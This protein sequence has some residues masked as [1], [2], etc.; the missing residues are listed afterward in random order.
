MKKYG[1]NGL[2]KILLL[3]R[4]VKHVDSGRMFWDGAE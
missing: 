1:K 4:T 2:T 3:F